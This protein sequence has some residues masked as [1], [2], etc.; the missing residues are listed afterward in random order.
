M[1]LDSQLSGKGIAE[2]IRFLYKNP[3]LLECMAE[4]AR[5]QA[6]PDAASRVVCACMKLLRTDV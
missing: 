1:I 4:D 6:I 3:D 2:E 5:K